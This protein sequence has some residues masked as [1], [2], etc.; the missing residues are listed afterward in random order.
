MDFGMFEVEICP[1]RTAHLYNHQVV[2]VGAV[3]GGDRMI[4]SA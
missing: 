2:G 4:A 3:E 1:G